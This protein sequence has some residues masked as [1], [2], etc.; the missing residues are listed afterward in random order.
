MLLN[1]CQLSVFVS[2]SVSYAQIAKLNPFKKDE[3]EVVV[4]HRG[5]GTLKICLKNMLKDIRILQRSE[6]YT[7]ASKFTSIH[8]TVG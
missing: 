8:S 5:G 6:W 2:M 1:A 3:N 4:V 7:P